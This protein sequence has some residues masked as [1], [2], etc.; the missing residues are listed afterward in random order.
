MAVRRGF[1]FGLLGMAAVLTVVLPLCSRVGVE[2]LRAAEPD[3]TAPPAASEEIVAAAAPAEA[4]PVREQVVFTEGARDP[5][6]PAAGSLPAPPPSAAGLRSLVGALG[7]DDIPRNAT[8]AVGELL[9]AGAAAVPALQDALHSRDP[10]QRLLAAAILRMTGAE[11]T[12]ALCEVLVESL[13]AAADDH[14]ARTLAMSPA[15]GAARWL[16]EHAAAARPALQVGLA[17]GDDRQRFLSAFLLALGGQP[18]DSG[19]V[20]KEL[21]DHL[22][23]NWIEGDALMAAHA[24]YR[25]GA[26]G[27]PALRAWR[28]WLDEQARQLVDLIEL[29]LLDP[30]RDHD[31]LRARA[32]R[33]AVT[34]VYHDPVLHFDL[35]RSRVAI[36]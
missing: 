27:L 13:G 36:W 18:D 12:P 24:L 17:S 5:D 8:H 16:A 1:W 23:D 30:P 14:A 6:E 9:R 21:V 33:H 3:P 19:A 15:V 35:H 7:A 20:T 32:R 28:P 2:P 25:L 34:T 29:D 4:E 11:A 31:Q 22:A 10:Q 26:R